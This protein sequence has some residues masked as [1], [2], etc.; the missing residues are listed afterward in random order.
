MDL[1]GKTIL[2]T[3]AASGI[4]RATAELLAE[5]GAGRLILVDVDQR[6][7]DGLSLDCTTD[8]LVGDVSDEAFWS[9]AELGQIDHAVVNAG[10]AGGGLIADLEFAEWRRTLRVNLDG[11]FLSL[12]EALRAIREG[13]SIVA[14]A[15]AA[16]LKAEPGVAAYG[17]SKAGLIQLARIAAKEA[18]VRDVRV[19]VVAPGGVE[20]PIWNEVPTFSERAKQLGHEPAF[21]ELAA[22]A[23]P[24]KR[25]AKPQEIAEQI[26]FLLSDACTTVTGS[27]LV[28]DGG[29]TL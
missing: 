23:T 12:R 8:R 4:G 21:R 1:A 7:L 29:Y 5:R 25:F 26:A 14:V 28:S 6:S 11:A 15:S 2:I 9:S 10:V 17:A 19:N 16:G 27:V 24:L 18:A 20:T 22:M 3:G 13:G